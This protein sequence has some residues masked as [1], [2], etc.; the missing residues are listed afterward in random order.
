[1]KYAARIDTTVIAG[2]LICAT[3]WYASRAVRDML[4]QCG[5]EIANNIQFGRD[6]TLP[7]A[8]GVRFAL[9]SAIGRL[10]T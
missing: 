3:E 6:T 10:F 2:P 1:M 8:E 7:T 4:T 9:G 5:L